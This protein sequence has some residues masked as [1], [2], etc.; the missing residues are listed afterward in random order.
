[1]RYFILPFF[2]LIVE[3]TEGQK[4][5][6]DKKDPF[7]NERQI[8]TD[9]QNLSPILKVGA[10]VIMTDTSK[11]YFLTFITQAIPGLKAEGIDSAKRECKIKTARSNIITG[12]WYGNA[13]I[14]IGLKIYD[15]NS[16]LFE[17]SDFKTIV[18]SEI[19]DIKLNQG[20][21]SIPEKNKNKIAKLC[22]LL[23]EKI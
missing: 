8:V 20:L 13:Q 7:T 3:K 11:K 12:S 16:Y 21:F 6:Y 4:I 10:M 5:F 1:M 17:E 14:P 22:G 18:T 9:N 15:S 23:L 19:T 2:I